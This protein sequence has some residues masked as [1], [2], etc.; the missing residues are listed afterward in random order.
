MAKFNWD[1]FEKAPST[2]VSG[3]FSW[4]EFELAQ[5]PSEQPK[6]SFG[7]S[8]VLGA[9]QGGMAGYA[10][11]VQGLAESA[12]AFEDNLTNRNNP[13]LIEGDF[14]PPQKNYKQARDD[15][16]AMYA[17]A[18]QDRPGAY[19]L[20]EVAGGVLSP[21]NK[22]GKGLSL[23]KQGAIIGGINSLGNSEADT[24]GGM[25]LDT[26]IGTGGGA[27]LGKATE[28]ATPYVEKGARYVGGKL[29][30][31][32]ETQ[33]FKAGGAALK[34]FRNAVERK[35]V[36]ALGR[37]MLDQGDVKAFSSVE[38]IA[39]RAGE[40]VK[41][42]GK[43]LDAIYSEAADKFEGAVT[44]IG[45]D[46]KRDKDAILKTV[47]EELGN[48]E[49]AEAAVNRVA[50]YLDEIAARHGDKPAEQAQAA[51]QKDLEKYLPRFRQ[52]LKDK[53]DYIRSVGQAG[54]DDAQP[55]LSG[56]VDDLQR[57]KMK[58]TQVEVNGQ[59]AA[60]MSVK[61]APEPRVQMKLSE[62]PD[63]PQVQ[64][65]LFNGI[66]S[67]DLAALGQNIALDD[68]SSKLI[69][70]ATP[71]KQ[72]SFNTGKLVPRKYAEVETPVV[73]QMTGQTRMVAQ[74]QAPARPVR[75]GDI[76]NPMT[77]RG[78]NDV[79]S[80]IDQVINYSRN[81]L[82]K[83]PTTERAFVAA[84]RAV[85][86]KVDDAID[87]LGGD[88]LLDSLKAANKEY[89][90]AKQISNIAQDRSNRNA[91]NKAM[92]GL[93]DVITGAGALGY[94]AS[95]N[96][97]G[98]AAGIVAAK[99]MAEKYGAS[100]AAVIFDRVS[101]KLLQSPPMVEMARQNPAVFKSVVIDIS[102]RLERQGT[103][104]LPK[105]A[106]KKNELDRDSGTPANEKVSPP[107]AP[108]PKS[109]PKRGRDK[110][111]EDG[112]AKVAKQGVKID[113]SSLDDPKIKE[114]LIQASDLKPGS[115]AMEQ[116]LTRIKSRTRKDKA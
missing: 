45:F 9:L 48:A 41:E 66:A 88:V 71:G 78:T 56:V 98:T 33:A 93:T 106:E 59:P 92:F 81:P 22:I 79:K 68:A 11:E 2:K 70:R 51:Y 29:K 17:K 4:D 80:E 61:P 8:L 35:T 64:G 105:A 58:P 46:P 82:T 34:D 62:I 16:R 85:A 99:R 15:A 65:D 19:I 43:K 77:P 63:L 39:A 96:D 94:G 50:K 36:K 112:L 53:A 60:E 116:V 18:R 54:K 103:F 107:A 115:K 110:W 100:T 49:G 102:R 3:S 20:G 24:A 86:E 44:K 25:L 73:E 27:I 57:T 108:T 55:V 28:V 87:A 14:I 83:Q 113:R 5:P 101:K 31:L 84:R 21:V 97:W 67:K 109:E 52:Y 7:E 37:E 89:G 95:T 90:M 23:A 6:A 26:A 30:D 76:R 40:R 12:P 114:L 69:A 75:P 32:A 72:G 111:A 13:M 74:P 10:D 1:D 104:A 91:A 42:A 47:R 38:D